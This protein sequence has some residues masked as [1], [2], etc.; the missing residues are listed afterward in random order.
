MMKLQDYGFDQISR[1]NRIPLQLICDGLMV[2][3]FF[4]GAE[5]NGSFSVGMVIKLQ[6][7]HQ[8]KLRMVVGTGT[9][10][11]VELVAL[12]ALLWFSHEKQFSIGLVL[13]DSKSTVD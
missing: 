9:N 1:S 12:W 3:R 13:C 7:N 8:F 4:D 5:E 6:H 11:K 10:T 2:T